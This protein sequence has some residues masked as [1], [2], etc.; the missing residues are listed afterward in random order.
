VDDE[1]YER[2]WE[3]VAAIDVAKATGGLTRANGTC[4]RRNAR[5]G[6]ALVLPGNHHDPEPPQNSQA[7]KA[8]KAR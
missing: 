8:G 3:R 2:V 5:Q 4:P 7:R 1:A 6:R